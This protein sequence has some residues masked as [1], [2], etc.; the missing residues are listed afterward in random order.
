MSDFQ[1]RFHSAIIDGFG[2]NVQ[3]Y[4]EGTDLYS[5]GGADTVDDFFDYL[6]AEFSG[7]L[8]TEERQQIR[9]VSQAWAWAWQQFEREQ[10]EEAAVAASVTNI[11][12]WQDRIHPAQRLIL[13]MSYFLGLAGFGYGMYLTTQ[14]KDTKMGGFYSGFGMFL[15]LQLYWGLNTFFSSLEA[16]N[17]KMLAKA[18]YPKMFWMALGS[19]VVVDFFLLGAVSEF[20]LGGLFSK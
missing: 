11:S 8:S 5:L 12:K 19:I 9:Y 1:N 4:T 16:R 18:G 14:L 15:A 10:A 17:S 7:D 13:R 20:V 2:E 3:Q 6:E